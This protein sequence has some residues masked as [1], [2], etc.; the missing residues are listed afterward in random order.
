MYT[1]T[2]TFDL[3]TWISVSSLKGTLWVKYDPDTE[4]ETIYAAPDKWCQTGTALGPFMVRCFG[5]K[6]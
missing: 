2:L 1:V 3:E 6:F 5:K 4:K